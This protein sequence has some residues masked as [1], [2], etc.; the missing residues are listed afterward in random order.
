MVAGLAPYS[1]RAV[2]LAQRSLAAAS[3][4][5]GYT[6]VGSVFSEPICCM[7]IVSTLD[8]DVQVSW[9]GTTDH[10]VIASGATV[11][12]DF[13]SDSIVFPGNLGVYAKDLGNP[14]TGSLYVSTFSTSP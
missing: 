5:A 6:I 13:K 3:I 14:T 12:I 11:I 9:D 4:V 8:E 2:P 1:V 7:I 10:I